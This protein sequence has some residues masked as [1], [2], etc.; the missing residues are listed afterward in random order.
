MLEPDSLETDSLDID[1]LQQ[2][3]RAGHHGSQEREGGGV[4]RY[5]GDDS[6]LTVLGAHVLPM[7]STALLLITR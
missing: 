5:Q 3:L 1:H 7:S 6:L 4:R 2:D